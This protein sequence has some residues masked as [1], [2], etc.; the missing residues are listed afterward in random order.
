MP[1]VDEAL[2]KDDS[3]R[4]FCSIPCI[5][6][7]RSQLHSSNIK[8]LKTE[9]AQLS[10]TKRCYTY[11]LFGFHKW[12]GG[13]QFE[14][15]PT[16]QAVD[17]IAR[18]RKRAVTL[19]GI[20]HLL[21]L[22]QHNT[23]GKIEFVVLIKKYLIHLQATK[24]APTVDNAMFAI[25]SFFRENDLE[26]DFRFN[27]S[28]RR[29][30]LTSGDAMTLD[31]LRRIFSTKGIQ[32]IERAV[33]MCKFHRGLDSSTLADRFNFEAWSQ[34]VDH[35][36]TADSGLWDTSKCPVPIKLVRVKTNYPHTGFLDADAIAA[37]QEYLKTRT[38]AKAPT[39]SKQHIVRGSKSS[40][41]TRK[42][43]RVGEALFLDTSGNPI[44]I[45]WIGRRFGKLRRRSGVAKAYPSHEMRDLLKSTLID[46][47]CRPDVADHVIG[48]APK[49]SYEK[50]T[51]LYPENVRA[52]FAKVSN[53][54][55]VLGLAKPPRNEKCRSKQHSEECVQVKASL[56]D[57]LIRTNRQLCDIL[58]RIRT[59]GADTSPA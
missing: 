45:N 42:K 25:K 8:N 39:H 6:Y 22:Y 47:G 23:G 50:Q 32:P 12:L 57:D 2:R 56:I 10:G 54:I 13:K 43:P 11:G 4:R 19:S 17:G 36:G 27:N 35:F 7:W 37:L 38:V 9:S 15:A 58:S 52:E 40:A 18:M 46:S 29:R 30:D 5:E 31:D 44:S 28:K 26:I 20:D 59:N 14:Y 24:N 34:M 1:T 49:D 16:A 51:L 3:L 53:R 21:S 48:H 55:N 41:S 33:F